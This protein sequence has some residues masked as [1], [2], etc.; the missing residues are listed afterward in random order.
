MLL[1]VKNKQIKL[2]YR[3]RHTEPRGVE[4]HCLRPQSQNVPFEGD[5]VRRPRSRK[6]TGSGPDVSGRGGFESVPRE[7]QVEMCLVLGT[8]FLT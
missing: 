5:G 8:V 4:K 7:L 6:D 2:W 1:I 3:I